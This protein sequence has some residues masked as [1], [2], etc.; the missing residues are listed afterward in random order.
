MCTIL[1]EVLLFIAVGLLL[2]EE[3][4]LNNMH[5]RQG[6]MNKH[7]HSTGMVAIKQSRPQFP[8]LQL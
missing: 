7:L 8:V 5:A 2:Q 4:G 6:G 1:Y 3:K